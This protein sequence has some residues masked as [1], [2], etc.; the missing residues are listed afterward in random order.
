MGGLAPARAL[1]ARSV[2]QRGAATWQCS[3]TPDR[4]PPGASRCRTEGTFPRR[5]EMLCAQIRPKGDTGSLARGSGSGHRSPMLIG[6]AHRRL[7]RLWRCCTRRAP[8]ARTAG[9]RSVAGRASRVERLSRSSRRRRAA[10]PAGWRRLGRAAPWAPGWHPAAALPGAVLA[11]SRR[12]QHRPPCLILV[13]LASADDLVACAPSPSAQVVSDQVTPD[14]QTDSSRRA[15]TPAPRA[16][17]E[18]ARSRQQCR[19]PTLTATP[20][21]TLA[22]SAIGI[23]RWWPDF[24]VSSIPWERS[25]RLYDSLMPRRPI[26]IAAL[27]PTGQTCTESRNGHCVAASFCSP[28][29]GAARQR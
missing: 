17:V 29:S 28:A 13:R 23:S 27:S 6:W 18:A 20:L 26:L 22:A 24:G 5:S 25:T 14:A 4:A 11:R 8:Q 1:S 2:R 15:P 10:R 7:R 16:S 19:P 3:P 21:S 9:R 12:G